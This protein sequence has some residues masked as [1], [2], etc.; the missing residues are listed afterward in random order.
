MATPQS[1]P[2]VYLRPFRPEDEPA[3]IDIYMA[4]YREHP[5]YGEP[6]PQQARRYLQWLMRHHTLFT[7]AEV[8][9]QPVGFIVV[10]ATWLDRSRRRVG[11]IHE[12]AVH[13]AYWGKGIARR[14]L[15]AGLAHIRTRGLTCAG[16]WVG[17]H[18]ERAQAFYRRLGFR[19]TQKG[20]GE[21]LRMVKRV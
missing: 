17:E 7:V 6:T 8:D 11:E 14:L 1:A 15:E 18:N 12:L 16:L 20:W 4:A 19:P 2:A 9:G 3:L 5:E 13:P 10:D 21:W